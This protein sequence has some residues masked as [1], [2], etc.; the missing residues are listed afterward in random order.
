MSK[1]TARLL[2]AALVLLTTANWFYARRTKAAPQ[3]VYGQAAC[4]S[5]VP[6]SW[7]EY[8]GSSEH[9]GVVFED[10][11]GTLRFVTNVPCETTPQVALEIRRTEPP[12]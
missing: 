6:L 7:G 11:S 12:R 4:K 2:V 1:T 9:Y 10:S 8:K 3:I 5:Y